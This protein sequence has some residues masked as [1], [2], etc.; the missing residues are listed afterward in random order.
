MANDDA[1]MVIV[2]AGLAGARAAQTLR[3]EGFA[4]RVVLVGDEQERPYERPPLSKE[5]LQGHAERD[6]V[7]VH[8]DHWY[9]DHGIELRLGVP[10]TG[11]EPAVHELVLGDGDR[12]GYARLLLATGSSPRRLHV[13]GANLDGVHTLRTLADCE[14]I[15]AAVRTSAHIVVIGAGWVGL[16]VA[17]AAR[18]AEVPVTVIEAASLPLLRV[19]GPEIAEVFARL[20]REHGVD[21][22]CDTGLAEVVGRDGRVAGVRLADG[23]VIDTDTVVVGIGV[24]PNTELAEAAGLEVDG[25]VVVDQYHRSSDPD[26][27]AAGD[28]AS[29]WHPAHGRHL[30]VEHWANAQDGGPAAA[31]A[32]LG[33]GPPDDRLPY[34]FTDQYDLGMEYTGYA[35]P[36]GYNEVIV[37][38]D[39]ATRE[40]VAFWLSG[41]RVLAGMN[42]NVW[43]VTE[44]VQR[45]IRSG[46]SV[47]TARLADPTIRL[48]DVARG[49]VPR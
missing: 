49:P 48:D 23:T 21:L 47:A 45:L 13:P 30:R 4:G 1:A 40:F 2:G 6:S 32:M 37:R 10:A 44:S 27:Y 31:R 26:V 35:A 42:V 46:Q 7:F 3:E 16:E 25:G 41:G 29:L 33:A 43:N 20:H 8:P 5:Y 15:A 28:V 38:G 22:R 11:I 39:L 12:V 36:D 24:S 18:A 17:A 19:L 9:A 14:R 34:F